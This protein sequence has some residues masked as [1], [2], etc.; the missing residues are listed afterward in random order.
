MTLEKLQGKGNLKLL[1]TEEK[2]KYA[3][4]KNDE[5]QEQLMKEVGY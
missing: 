4:S 2:T 5:E 3:P 1:N